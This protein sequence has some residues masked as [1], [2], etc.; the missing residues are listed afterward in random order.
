MLSVMPGDI[1]P[2]N[3]D[4]VFTSLDPLAEVD[5]PGGVGNDEGGGGRLLGL[6]PPRRFRNC[7]GGGPLFM[8]I[9]DATA[10]PGLGPWPGGG[11][12][13]LGEN[14]GAKGGRTKPGPP[15]AGG[16]PGGPPGIGGI[17][18]APWPP[19]GKGGNAPGGAEPGG[20]VGAKGGRVGGRKGAESSV[21]PLHRRSCCS[22]FSG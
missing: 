11:Y 10:C 12:C 2:K 5:R 19:G 17:P 8:F 15:I 1:P 22:R 6:L 18:G 21:S 20:R 13:P 16:I 3:T 4:V 9:G 7:R 14:G